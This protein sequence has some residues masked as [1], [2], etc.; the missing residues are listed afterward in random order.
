MQSCPRPGICKPFLKEPEA[1][2]FRL[3]WPYGLCCNYS[4]LLSQ[5]ESS[6][7]KQPSNRWKSLAVCW[8]DISHWIMIKVLATQIFLSTSTTLRRREP[9]KGELQ[10]WF[11]NFEKMFSPHHMAYGTLK[12]LGQGLNPYLLHW[13]HGVSTTGLP[14][15][16]WEW[17]LYCRYVLPLPQL[18]FR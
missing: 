17:F 18:F 13:Q 7:R 6:H 2:S 11:L 8:E 10:K 1:K 15:K 9:R 12:F 3:W 14:G 5:L 4:T 16:S